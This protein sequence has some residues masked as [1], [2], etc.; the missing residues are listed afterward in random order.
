MPDMPAPQPFHV[1]L[2]DIAEPELGCLDALLRGAVEM[3]NRAWRVVFGHSD[4]DSTPESYHQSLRHQDNAKKRLLVALTGPRFA[5]GEESGLPIVRPTD[6]PGDAR[7]IGTC[8][9]VQSKHDNQHVFDGFE[10]TVDLDHRRQ[11]VATAMMEAVHQ[12]ARDWGISTLI[13]WGTHANGAG[14][15]DALHPK[16]GEFSISRDAAARFALKQGFHLAQCERHSVQTVR[17][18]PVQVPAAPEGYEV[19]QWTNETPDDLLAAKALLNVAMSSD[20]PK[21][22]LEFEDEVWTAERVAS[23]EKDTY[24]DWLG[25]TTAAR[26]VE[27]G[28]LAGYTNIRRRPSIEQVAWQE[29]TIVLKSHRGHG[30][31]EL[32]KAANLDYLRRE[33]PT[34]ERVHTWNAGENRWMLAI[35]D[36][37]GY[38]VATVG[39]AWQKKI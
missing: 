11:G 30:L 39:G 12:V 27:S 6:D 14:D 20:V 33:W 38:K 37:L 32:M 4:F 19:L 7:V 28:E 35:N 9:L 34:T 25:L 26:H 2:V 16:E 24:E 29:V 36:R 10:I 1:A 15:P 13:S 17:E 3:D 8:L 5:S 21:G 18:S 31:G 23:Q 22:E